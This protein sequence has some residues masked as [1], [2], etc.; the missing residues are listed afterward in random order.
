MLIDSF[1]GYFRGVE[2]DC[3]G[4]ANDQAMLKNSVWNQKSGA[5]VE[6]HE[7]I[8]GDEGY[9]DAQQV[10]VVKPMS[11]TELDSEPGFKAF[12]KKFNYDRGL[13]EHTFAILKEKFRIFDLPW[14]RH[15]ELFPLA[16]RVCLFE[17]IE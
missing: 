6:E 1:W 16:L 10:N 15:K 3:A 17:V 5:L 12:N 2:I 11:Q 4:L 13:I 9:W 8:G 14:T 7:Y